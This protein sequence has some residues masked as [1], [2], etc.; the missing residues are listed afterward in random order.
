MSQPVIERIVH[1]VAP[2]GPQAGL[3]LQMQFPQLVTDLS[4]GAAGDFPADARAGRAEAQAHCAYVPVLGG[5]P[6]DRVLAPATASA[7]GLLHGRSL[8]HWLPIWLP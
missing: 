2:P 6:V 1:G 5:V 8:R 4:F 7:F 3:N